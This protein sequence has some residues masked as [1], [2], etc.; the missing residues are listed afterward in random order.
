MKSRVLWIDYLRSFIILLVVAHHS[1]LAYT[2]FANFNKEAYI[3]STHPIVD[4]QR[5]IGLDIFVFF[6]DIYFMS[7]MF[8]I[9]GV[10]VLAS[11]QKKGSVSFLRDRFTRLFIPFM[12]GVTVLMLLAYYPSYYLAHGQNNIKD[13]IID[14]FTTE[15]WPVG[16]L[17]FIWVLFLFNL[18]LV[19]VLPFMKGLLNK[20]SESLL[21]FKDKPLKLF[22]I[23]FLL[24]W[25]LYVPARLLFGPDSWTGFGPFDFQKSR[26]LLYFGYFILGAVIG[27]AAYE[28]GL[29][30]DDSPFINKWS[31]WIVMCLL[32]FI[33]LI[34]IDGPLKRLVEKNYINTLQAQLIYSIVYVSSCTLSCIAFL[35]AFKALVKSSRIWMDSLVANSFSIYIIH[36]I[37]ITWCQYVLLSINIPAYIKFGITFLFV[38]SV[39]W[40]TSYLIRKNYGMKKYL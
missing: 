22:I 1:A 3:L 20:L 40:L 28:K 34:F 33:L 14:F 17:W 36:Y 32:T 24:T 2:T 9:S 6:N 8:L 27:N 5:W 37:F 15:S 7:L 39:S 38:F 23:W 12:F 19:L 11:L 26:L 31:L 35:T 29:F 16:P 18:V 10:F 4:I 21:T 30:S 25:M 13:Y